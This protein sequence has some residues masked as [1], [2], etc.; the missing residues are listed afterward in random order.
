MKEFDVVRIYKKIQK[1]HKFS[2]LIICFQKQQQKYHRNFQKPDRLHFCF[3]AVFFAIDISIV[4]ICNSFITI[5]P[6]MFKSSFI[7]TIFVVL[8]SIVSLSI[9]AT[10]SDGIKTTASKL[11]QQQQRLSSSPSTSPTTIAD[12]NNNNFRDSLRF[13][14]KL[15]NDAMLYG[16]SN[17]G[18]LSTTGIS[19]TASPRLTPDLLDEA[20]SISSA[21]LGSSKEINVEDTMRSILDADI[22]PQP[23]LEPGHRRFQSQRT[24][25]IKNRNNAAIADDQRRFK[26]AVRTKHTF[27]YRPVKIEQLQEQSE[28]KIIEVEAR[29]LPL[30]I[31]FKSAS[32]RIKMVQEHQKGELQQE[33]RTQ[34]VEEPQRMFHLVR[35][36]I[37]QEVREIISPYRRIVQEIQ[38]VLEEIHTVIAHSGQQHRH[39][40]EQQL[41]G[42][43]VTLNSRPT[44]V[45]I[46]DDD[47]MV[48][49]DKFQR[50]T[51]KPSTTAASAAISTSL[52]KNTAP[53]VTTARPKIVES[54][55]SS[56]MMRN[57]ESFV[58]AQQQQSQSTLP[59][60]L[61][62]APIS[63]DSS[64]Y[65]T[66]EFERI[67]KNDLDNQQITPARQQQIF[68]Q[69]QIQRRHAPLLSSFRHAVAASNQN[70]HSIRP[71]Q[72]QQWQPNHDNNWNTNWNNNNNHHNNNNYNPNWNGNWN[73]NNHHYNNNNN[74][75]Y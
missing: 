50:Q 23:P 63:Y 18:G 36:P 22:G 48:V 45:E 55:S 24:N 27:E 10:K 58:R 62:Q 14:M 66:S 75:R 39:E 33:Q 31:H 40:D 19:T 3:V 70:Y 44:S 46:E 54:S 2:I 56:N 30:E 28:P 49:D 17:Y 57:L 59:K 41:L 12:N 42:T 32:S 52:S 26:A 13:K 20:L 4:H 34:S 7:L 71:Q 5:Q 74:N 21:E 9:A 29:S 6:K 65:D 51:L 69:Q 72:Q 8:T 53:V 67:N 15:V 38:P 73:N 11:S 61:M 60:R 25:G 1:N 16:G 47:A 35:K 43:D 64:S 37:I 68:Q